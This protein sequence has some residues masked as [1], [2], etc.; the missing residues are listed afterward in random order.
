M[1]PR[2]IFLCHFV[3]LLKLALFYIYR[4]LRDEIQSLFGHHSASHSYRYVRQV[5][6]IA[7]INLSTKQLR[8]NNASVGIAVPTFAARW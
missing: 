3:K 8:D 6:A 4:S 2:M 7:K 1:V 5:A